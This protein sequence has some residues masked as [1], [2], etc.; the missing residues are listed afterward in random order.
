[1]AKTTSRPAPPEQDRVDANP[2]RPGDQFASGNWLVSQDRDTEF[3]G[4]WKEFLEW[5][6]A[7]VAGLRSAHLIQDREDPQHFISFAAWESAE[8]MQAWRSLPDFGQ[9]L[10]ACRA[11]CDDFRGSSY[12]LAAMA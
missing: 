2:G 1:M 7:S 9:H 12:T 4:R 3:V 6:R 5:T 11:L 10:N 8:A